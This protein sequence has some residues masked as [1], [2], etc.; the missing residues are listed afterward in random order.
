VKVIVG[1]GNPGREY[2]KTRHNIGFA[3]VDELCRRHDASKPKLRFE[4]E[5]AE[6]TIGGEKCLLVR[7]QTYMNLS[8]RS[9]RQIIDF[10]QVPLTDLIVVSDDMNLDV[11]K[12]RLRPGGSAGGQKGL[13]DILKH[14]AT[15][16]FARLRIGIG[17]PPGRMISTDYVLG[18]FRSDEKSAI[19]HATVSAAD[20]VETW[21]GRGLQA[22]MNA[23][24]SP[25]PDEA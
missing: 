7:P 14:L 3:V 21:V 8:G 4:A 25:A 20:G 16:D 1:L 22:A 6:A 10:Y 19:D 13:S 11:G 2:E 24:N 17:R 15:E 23:V 5:I 18:K 12:L 9:V